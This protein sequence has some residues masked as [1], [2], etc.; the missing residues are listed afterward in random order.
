MKRTTDMACASSNREST[1]RYARSAVG[2]SAVRTLWAIG[3]LAARRS[4]AAAMTGIRAC[5]GIS[6]GVAGRNGAEVEEQFD[7]ARFMVGR[8]RAAGRTRYRR[9]SV[10][11]GLVVVRRDLG[12]HVTH[13]RPVSGD[14]D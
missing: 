3:T 9:R 14:S 1:A 10:L 8:Q 12:S 7:A 2:G 11:D 4:A 13:L 5:R 6:G